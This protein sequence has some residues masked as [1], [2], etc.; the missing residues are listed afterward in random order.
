MFKY[1]KVT[2]ETVQIGAVTKP[3]LSPMLFLA[4]SHFQGLQYLRCS[5]I[6][7]HKVLRGRAAIK[8]RV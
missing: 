2:V 4:H 7:G 1:D 5:F 8:C 6:E 3:R